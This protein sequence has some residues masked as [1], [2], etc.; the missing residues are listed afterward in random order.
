MQFQPPQEIAEHLE[1]SRHVPAHLLNRLLS[2]APAPG[3]F[4]RRLSLLRRKNSCVSE[5]STTYSCL[6]QDTQTTDCT[7]GPPGQT[8]LINSVHFSTETE[9]AGPD[10]PGLST[11][12]HADIPEADG[13]GLRDPTQSM[14]DHESAVA[15]SQ[16]AVPLVDTSVSA[17]DTAMSQP[18]LDHGT[19]DASFFHNTKETHSKSLST[20]T[21]PPWLQS[22]IEEENVA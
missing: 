3:G 9:E 18:L 22:P 11:D 8:S 1:H 20:T 10:A 21:Y 7:C 19:S 5:A 14:P 15:N 13:D 4:G 12:T 17:P 2:T 6:C 16:D